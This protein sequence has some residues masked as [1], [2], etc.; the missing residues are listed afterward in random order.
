MAALSVN[1]FGQADDLLTQAKQ[2]FKE[3][4]DAAL[5]ED[6]RQK[7]HNVSCAYHRVNGHEAFNNGDFDMALMHFKD[8][9]RRDPDHPYAAKYVV[10]CQG[11]ASSFPAALKAIDRAA[12]APKK[13][14]LITGCGRSG[15]WLLAAMIGC[16]DGVAFM[17]AES[18]VGL[19]ANMKQSRPI[20]MVK[21]QHDTY[22]Y[23]SRIHESLFVLHIVRHP[24]DVLTSRHLDQDRFITPE[25]Y[26]LEMEAY[27]D[28]LAG[29][30]K[31]LTVRYED[32]VAAPNDLQV[33]I[34]A[35]ADLKGG[36]PFSEFYKNNNFDD[37][38]LKS[39]HGLRPVSTASIGKWK[40][41]V[42]DR[43][44]L[45]SLQES[46]AD[47]FEY[48]AQTFGYDLSIEA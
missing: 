36:M 38:T 32:L 41:N 29:R 42:D 20:H 39:M 33:K 15:T 44:F 8:L 40:N 1:L 10:K 18:P 2:T 6:C 13:R 35:E 26:R 14:L 48:T 31:G 5:L 4:K 25:N 47:I 7:I 45:K 22:K 17:P 37:V 28:H 30:E 43:A 23:F 3:G 16:F 21:R 24:Y 46:M 19:F 34:A 11:F 27:R 9:A 12:G